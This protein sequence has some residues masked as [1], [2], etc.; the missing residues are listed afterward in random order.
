MTCSGG[1]LKGVT[2]GVG[3]LLTG[4]LKHVNSGAAEQVG[5]VGGTGYR[6]SQPVGTAEG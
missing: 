2:A 3:A 1:G 6:G 5:D 4:I